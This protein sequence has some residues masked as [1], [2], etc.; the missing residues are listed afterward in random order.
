MGKRISTTT[1][2]A[3]I[4]AMY[5][6]LT[7]LSQEFGLASGPIQFRISEALA[8]LPLLTY[9]AVPGLTMG[10]LL[11]NAFTGCAL[12]DII[13]GAAATLIGAIGTYFF[14]KKPIIGIMCPILSNTLIIP[15]ILTFVYGAEGTYPY[16]VLTVFLGE[17]VT[18]GLLGWI[19]YKSIKKTKL[20]I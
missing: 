8:I 10:C 7:A 15:F 6:V 11:A 4:A 14:R 5:L 20:F 9:S 12:W 1:E 19:L 2:A 16:F 3:L 17:V 13:G 18:V